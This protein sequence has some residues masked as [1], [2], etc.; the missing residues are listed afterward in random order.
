[1]SRPIEANT[2]ALEAREAAAAAREAAAA[3]AAVRD[4]EAAARSIEAAAAKGRRKPWRRAKATAAAEEAVERQAALVLRVQKL[5]VELRAAGARGRGGARARRRVGAR[6]REEGAGGDRGAGRRSSASAQSSPT[7]DGAARLRRRRS[8]L[9]D[10]AQA[11][12]A[13]GDADV[14]GRQRLRKAT[15]PHSRS[16]FAR[17]AAPVASPSLDALDRLRGAAKLPGPPGAGRARSA[18]GALNIGK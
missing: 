15:T 14:G 8:L 13:A 11:A 9:D 12:G 17:G 16:L 18:L 4:R 1:M 3:K 2:Q 7:A 6:R 5:E 10:A